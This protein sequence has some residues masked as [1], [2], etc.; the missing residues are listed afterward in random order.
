MEPLDEAYEQRSEEKCE[1][2]GEKTEQSRRADAHVELIKH[3]QR[4][5]GSR[6]VVM[7]FFV[8]GFGFAR[9]GDTYLARE[10]YKA[11]IGKTD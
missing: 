10:H 7:Q 6:G 11:R 4:A 5:R 2:E 1:R 3:N 9:D 8:E